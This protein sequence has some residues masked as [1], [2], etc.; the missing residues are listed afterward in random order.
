MSLLVLLCFSRFL[1][2]S[3]GTQVLPVFNVLL[4][5]L[6]LCDVQIIHIAPK[7]SIDWFN[8][9]I[10]VK[11]VEKSDNSRRAVRFLIDIFKSRSALHCKFVI[12]ISPFSLN[13]REREWTKK[14]EEW[15]QTAHDG[16]LRFFSGE[17]FGKYPILIRCRNSVMTFLAPKTVGDKY[18][19]F[20]FWA[21]RYFTFSV[22]F[23]S[24]R[25]KLKVCFWFENGTNEANLEY[26]LKRALLLDLDKRLNLNRY[27]VFQ[28]TKGYA[29]RTTEW[30]YRHDTSSS[31]AYLEFDTLRENHNNPF[32]LKIYKPP[33][34][35]ILGIVFNKANETIVFKPCGKHDA[36]LVD[37]YSSGTHFDTA[38]VVTT[39]D[40]VFEFV[41]C[42]REEY[43]TFK[44]YVTPFKKYLWLSILISV[45]AIIV[46]TKAHAHYVEIPNTSPCFWL[47][48]LATI[49]EECGYLPSKIERHSFIR[50]VLGFWCLM[51][52]I[53]TNCYNGIMISDLNAPRES[54]RLT[55]FDNLLCE[56]LTKADALKIY[57]PMWDNMVRPPSMLIRPG[58][59]LPKYGYDRIA[60]YI[61][62][63]M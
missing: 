12:F 41:T 37:D 30:C 53:L 62:I 35:I 52:V 13:P 26:H 1:R 10:P 6:V 11:I 9:K 63:L 21:G 36:R 38:L 31:K 32:D 61:R 43:I 47:F 39:H 45:I 42:Y 19:R 24:I 29:I 56:R 55:L 33:Q 60:W 58:E 18:D 44:F 14:L 46:T 48:V 54:S 40:R 49:L 50:L 4:K 57:K 59:T 23:I 51:S 2:T 8:I 27:S 17:G 15:F 22:L 3:N 28:L 7:R 16:H 34:Q 25:N 5:N 20:Y